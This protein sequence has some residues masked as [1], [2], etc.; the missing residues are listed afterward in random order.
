MLTK[1]INHYKYNPMTQT[2][3]FDVY[4]TLI[5]TSGIYESLRNL[6]PS[7]A[8]KF[9]ATWRQKQ[10]EYSFRRGLMDRHTDFSVCTRDAFDYCC[11]LYSAEIN[12]NQRARLMNEYTT[13]PAFPDAEDCLKKCHVDGHR[14]FAFSNGS[15]KAV[16]QLMKNAGILSLFDGIVSAEDVE[17]FKPSPV[18]YNHFVEAT[19]SKTESTWLISGNTFDVMGARSCEW[20]AAWVQHSPKTVFDPWDEFKPTATIQSLTELP[21][22]L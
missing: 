14:V 2:L 16:N 9:M 12:S 1:L 21:G 3:A 22:V 17:M 5:N 18:V 10:L 11:L 4:G 19:E 6:I 13:L 7:Q 8:E 20:N 15:A